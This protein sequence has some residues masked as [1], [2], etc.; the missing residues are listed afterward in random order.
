MRFLLK[1]FPA[2]KKK[3]V[4]STIGVLALILFTSIIVF[5]TTK[6]EVRLTINGEQKTIHTHLHTVNE[7]LEEEGIVASEYDDLSH[8]LDTEIK[9]GM[10]LDY[11]A[12][13]QIT[14]NIDGKTNTYYSTA[15]TVGAFLEEENIDITK[16]DELS[17]KEQDSLEDGLHINIKKA[18]EVAIDDGGKE[19]S[20]QFTGGTVEDLLKD[21]EIEW[22]KDDKIKPKLNEEVEKGTSVQI[23]RIEKKEEEI[24]EEI[25]FDT[26]KKNDSSLEKGEEKVL[27][28]G[29]NGKVHKTYQVT[30]E[31]GKEVD[32]QLV[33][34]DIQE[35][36][37]TRVVAVGTKET[38][39]T[40]STNGSSSSANG[41]TLTMTASAFTA[42][43]SGCSGY[44]ATGLN[45]KA[46]PNQKVIAVDPSVIPLGTKVWVEG[47][48]EAIA[49]DTGGNIKGNRIDVHVPNKSKATNWGVRNVQVKILD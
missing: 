6:A 40:L 18:F 1:Q 26:E 44:T 15:Q 7:L 8:P 43:C 23:V 25:A 32:R 13:K 12:A 22:S 14:L 47:Y 37:V 3:L 49:G 28:E 5:E 41:K 27:T 46:N 4:I 39:Q 21:L 31:N 38:V 10:A 48:G 11:R 29:K 36:S 2:D 45:L 9:D 19:R 30:Y 20:V 17:L 35:E 42:S 16:H 33:D 24:V 34:E